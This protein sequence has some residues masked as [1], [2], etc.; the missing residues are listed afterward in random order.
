V[1]KS[2]TRVYREPQS[3]IE[4]KRK[5]KGRITTKKSEEIAAM[6]DKI[7]AQEKK[8]IQYEKVVRELTEKLNNNEKELILL[9]R[10]RRDV[11]NNY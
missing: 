7:D 8:I 6:E 3:W 11:K 4:N 1:V 9:N 2:F 10:S 5:H